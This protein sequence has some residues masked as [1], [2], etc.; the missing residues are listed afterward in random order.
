MGY[1]DRKTVNDL[2]NDH[3][4]C[5]YHCVHD[6]SKFYRRDKEMGLVCA[7]HDSAGGKSD[8][9]GDYTNCEYRNHPRIRDMIKEK[10][11]ELMKAQEQ[12]K[13]LFIKIA[14]FEGT[15]R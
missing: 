5:V 1:W 12:I 2:L 14:N 13:K 4:V 11:N 7:L 3:F 10:K 8:C 15:Y 9:N 6:D